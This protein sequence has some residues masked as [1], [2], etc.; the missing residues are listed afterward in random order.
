MTDLKVL[1]AYD[2]SELATLP[3]QGW[4]QASARLQRAYDRFQ[5]RDGWLAKHERI[6]ILERAA[7]LVSERAE[8]LA[9]QAAREGGKHHAAGLPVGVGHP[10][11]RGMAV[12]V[13]DHTAFRV[14]WM[15]FGGHLSSGLGLGGIGHSMRDMSLERMF[16]IRSTGSRTGRSS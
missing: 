13:N 9:V 10:A 6:A 12:M 1:A 3:M 15:P 16:V 2:G 5:N 4:A 7:R 11:G 8:D 14:D